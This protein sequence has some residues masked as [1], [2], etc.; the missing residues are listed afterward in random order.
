M[1]LLYRGQVLSPF[2]IPYWYENA[3]GISKGPGSKLCNGDMLGMYSVGIDNGV[4]LVAVGGRIVWEKEI[5]GA[6]AIKAISCVWLLCVWAAHVVS[7]LKGARDRRSGKGRRGKMKMACVVMLVGIM[8]GSIGRVEVVRGSARMSAV[9]IYRKVA[10]QAY[11]DTAGGL[12]RSAGFS[13]EA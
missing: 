5:R 6:C 3:E 11:E 13:R 10:E 4:R 1:H 12:T 8:C 7:V 2:G 9:S